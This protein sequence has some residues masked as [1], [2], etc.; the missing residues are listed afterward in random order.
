MTIVIADNSPRKTYTAMAGQTDFPTD[1]AFFAKA[2]VNVYVN[3]TLKTLDSDFSI[4]TTGPSA[5][6]SGNDGTIVFTTGLS[7]GDTVVLTRDVE[8][9]RTTDFPSSGPFQVATLNT[10]LD[11]I[12]AMIADLEDLASRGITLADS[13]TGD[14]ASLPDVAARKG[15]V[16]AFENDATAAP[17]AGPL[18]TDVQSVADVSADIATLADIEDGTDAT[19]AISDL[20]AVASDVS[21]AASNITAIQNASANATTAT[22][23]A[24]EAAA[25][26]TAAAASATAA[27]ASETAAETAETNAET[28]ET[29][30][31]TSATNAATS[32][33]SAASSATTA[34]TKASEA[35]TSATNAATSETNASTSATS[36]STSATAASTSATAAA[37]SATAAAASETAAAASET[38]AGTSETNASTSAT[39]A[40]TKASEASTSATNAAA[41]ATS[42]ASAQSAAESARDSALAA[43][44]NFDDRYLGA[45]S[46]EP[47]VDNDGDALV[48]G[49]LFFDTTAGA[50]KIY[51]GSAWVAAYVSGTDFAALS[52]ATFT[53]DVSFGDS[54]Q[55]IFGDGDDFRIT[56]NG[57][58]GKFLLAHP[59]N[60]SVSKSGGDNFFE[61]LSQT[62]GGA[63]LKLNST[64]TGGSQT[65]NAVNTALD[66]DIQH[67]G[68]TKLSIDSDS[69]DIT[70][71]LRVD[72]RIGIGEDASTFWKIVSDYGTSSS[73]SGIFF[74]HSYDSGFK[75]AAYY[76]IT[77]VGREGGAGGFAMASNYILPGDGSAGPGYTATSN[78][79]DLGSSQTMWADIY[80]GGDVYATN[81]KGFQQSGSWT[82]N[83]TPYGY[84][85]I[86]PANTSY[87]HIYTDRPNFY[88]NKKIYHDNGN[89][90]AGTLFNTVGSYCLAHHTSSNA[91]LSANASISGSSLRA[92]GFFHFLSISSSSAYYPEEDGSALSGTWRVM[93]E[94]R[95]NSAPTTLRPATLFV[96][97][98]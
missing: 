47:S 43:Y 60:L 68:T 1:F 86:G 80:I 13:D 29:N 4:P 28:A 66:L 61:I 48:A 50:M 15:R 3:G 17:K 30:A 65:I 40:T 91:S 10:E 70:D 12:V 25:S 38:A 39:T 11:K 75:T 42:A 67:G 52:G 89:L 32:A 33:T 56:F 31:A 93:G 22:T 8:L 97:I 35:S 79:I 84:I 16:L 45:K 98:S 77:Y 20:A 83:Q 69:V 62:A 81:Q 21:T 88:F 74:D 59:A 9:E 46:S 76:G 72:G 57:T 78:T 37:S 2:D 14:T 26:A 87:A 41:S 73:G 36:A 27:A 90:V 64:T 44:D 34:T 96:R 7:A 51:T 71:S 19:D 92:V 24:T 18:I 63:G 49:A 54:T 95:D 5:W 55:V 58:D 85:D 23:K 6:T 82:R 94:A 53:G